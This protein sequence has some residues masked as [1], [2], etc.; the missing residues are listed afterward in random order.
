MFNKIDRIWISADVIIIVERRN[1]MS[2]FIKKLVNRHGDL[3]SLIVLITA[4]VISQGCSRIF[5][6]PQE[7]E[8]LNDLF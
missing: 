1:V 7:P 6:Q 4:P 3:F 5:Y 2:G 8:N